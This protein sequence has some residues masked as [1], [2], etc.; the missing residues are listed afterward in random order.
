[1]T[2]MEW[3]QCGYNPTYVGA[4]RP[5]YAVY[6][7]KWINGTLNAAD[8]AELGE[9][10]RTHHGYRGY[11]PT[12]RVVVCTHWLLALANLS[13]AHILCLNYFYTVSILYSQVSA[14]LTTAPFTPSS[15]SCKFTKRKI[16]ITLFIGITIII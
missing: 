4:A 14:G 15:N 13:D 2:C 16:N 7:N 12:G 9:G 3:S 10:W 1:M 5:L 8:K 11:T 6:C